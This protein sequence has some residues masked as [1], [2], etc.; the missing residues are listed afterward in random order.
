MKNLDLN[1]KQIQAARVAMFNAM[2]DGDEE[3]QGQA[4]NDFSQS[5]QDTISEQANSVIGDAANEMT[6]NKI[7]EARGIQ[8]P[9]TSTERKFF[10]AAAQKQSFENLGETFPE[11]IVEDVLS[12]IQQEHPLL[13]AIDTQ[14]VSALM[15]VIYADPTSKTAFWGK[16]PDNIKQILT[17]GFKVLSLESSKLS[18][19][20]AVPKGFFKLGPAYLATY[21]IT[22]LEETM[23]ATLE[24]AVVSGTGKD[25]PIGMI[26]KLSGSV[27]GVYPDKPAIALNDLEPLSLAGIHGAL[28]KAK[29]D[30][31]QVAVIVNPMTYWAKLFAKLAVK[32]SDS[33]WHLITLPTG[34]VI[35]QSYAVPEDK[36]VFGVLK[37][38]VLGVSG[39][40]ELN[41]Y[42]QTLAIE[43]M[44]LFIAKFFGMGIA[45]NENAFFVADVSKMT[46]ATIPT[47]EDSADVKRPGR[48]SN[49]TDEP[50]LPDEEDGEGTDKTKKAAEKK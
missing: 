13:A 3:A 44:D 5:L 32:D 34:D 24:T 45:K 46:G 21:V 8:R 43:D 41:R 14:T 23:A 37:N 15:K 28:T 16:V 39:E 22:F 9:M 48:I 36:L 33:N 17:D 19:F 42:E 10:A 38:Y 47:L 27:D 18:G 30:N 4:F 26:K 35:V 31:G 25:M 7:L 12:R 6:D 40:M 50:T 1:N 20:L 29:T 2:R 49:V 11:T